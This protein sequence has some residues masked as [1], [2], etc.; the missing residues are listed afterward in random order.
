MSPPAIQI[1]DN[2]DDLRAVLA[3]LGVQQVP[4]EAD[5]FATLAWFDNLA[6]CGLDTTCQGSVK[7]RLW[8]LDGGAAGPVVCLPLLPGRQ[9]TGLSNYYSSLYAPLVW[10]GACADAPDAGSEK[11]IWQT[12]THAIRSHW[13]RWPVLRFDPLDPQSRFFSG[14]ECAL[15]QAGYQVGRYFCFG[16]WYLQLAGRSFAQYQESLPSALRH[17]ITRGQRRLDKQGP[18]RIDIQQQSDGFL[19][20]AIQDFVAVYQASWKGAEPNHHFI[21]AL[22]RTA[23][24]Q[25]WLRLGVLRLNDQPIAAQLWLVKGGKA[26]IF[27][28]AYVN[29]FERFSAGSVLTAALM[30][31]VIDVDQVKEVDYLTGD[32]AY[33]RDWMSHRRERWGLVAFDWRTLSGLW[34]GCRHGLGQWFKRRKHGEKVS[35]RVCL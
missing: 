2:F 28:L 4:D 6:T 29:G 1:L 22:A 18:W 34:A 25:G 31:H 8:L 7:C 24:A 12:F 10:P 16:N 13:A 17:S 26:S 9:L 21:P 11:A 23:A 33:K 14:F 35:I 19:E 30:R 32:D 27:K 20:S 5:V 3:Q 15:R